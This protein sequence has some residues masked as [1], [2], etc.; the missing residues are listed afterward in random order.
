MPLHGA[1][2]VVDEVVPIIEALRRIIPG[3]FIVF[4][5]IRDEGSS[6]SR[7]REDKDLIPIVP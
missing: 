6:S 7:D 5:M 4:S 3:R 1:G 2:K